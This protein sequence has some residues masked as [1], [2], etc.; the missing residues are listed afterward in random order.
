MAGKACEYH[1]SALFELQV[2]GLGSAKF[3]KVSGLKMG[4]E[5]EK[6]REGGDLLEA[7]YPGIANS[8]DITAVRG[9][10]KDQGLIDWFKQT[11]DLAAGTGA[12][13]CDDFKKTIVLVQK[14]RGQKEIRRY[15]IFGAW[16]KTIA[17][18]DW[19]NTSTDKAMETI[20]IVNDF[21]TV[22][23]S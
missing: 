7:K 5:V 10:T 14:N 20:E 16:V 4:V 17:H 6:Q 13:P 15:T 23:D 8:E 9:I 21:Y 19:D 1:S 18:G 22:T 11:A 2:P 3:M 12:S